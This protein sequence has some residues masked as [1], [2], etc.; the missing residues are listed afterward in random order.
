MIFQNSKDIDPEGWLDKGELTELL[1]IS[2]E[3]AEVRVREPSKD[4]NGPELYPEPEIK[5][6]ILPEDPKVIAEREGIHKRIQSEIQ[7][8]DKEAEVAVEEMFE[9][10]LAC[11][12]SDDR[13]QRQYDDHGSRY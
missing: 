3:E 8:E 9:V 13:I 4:W 7:H 5:L 2:W 12:S 6:P 11:S 1:E 10:P